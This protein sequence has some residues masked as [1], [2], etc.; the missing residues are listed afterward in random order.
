MNQEEIMNRFFK[1]IQE[2]IIKIPD[3]LK[4]NI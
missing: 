3:N 1:N 4:Q 2:K